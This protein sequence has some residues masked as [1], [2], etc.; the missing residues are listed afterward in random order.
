VSRI[1]TEKLLIELVREYLQKL[2]VKGEYNGKFTALDHFFG[3][4]GRC[5]FPTNFDSDYCYGLGYAAFLL[6]SQGLT[7]YIAN[8]SDL[9]KPAEEW[10][11]GGIPLTMMMNMEQRHGSRKPVIRKALVELDGAPFRAFAE[12]RDLWA[13]ETRYTYPGAIQYYGPSEVCD[14]PPMTLVLEKGS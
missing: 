13:V 1:D 2:K 7:G 12:N 3:Y 11:A 5:A 6:I 10:I 4:E 8:L 14:A 9:H